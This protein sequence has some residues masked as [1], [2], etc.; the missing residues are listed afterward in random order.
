[1]DGVLFLRRR[2]VAAIVATILAAGCSLFANTDRLSGSI[3]PPT[4]DGGDSSIGSDGSI[5]SA[6]A[7]P[8][9]ELIVLAS[10]QL[11]PSAIGLLGENVYFT[12]TDGNTVGVVPKAKGSVQTFAVAGGTP[13]LDVFPNAK[14][15]VWLKATNSL[16]AL[17]EMGRDGGTPHAIGVTPTNNARYVRAAE[18]GVSYV[19]AYVDYWRWGIVRLQKS[20]D[21]WS[22]VLQADGGVHA[23]ASDGLFSYASVDNNIIAVDGAGVTTT[24]AS[25]QPP[26]P[27]ISTDADSVF[28]LTADGHVYRLDKKDAGGTPV[29]LA[30]D[31]AGLARIALF[32]EN[33]YFTVGGAMKDGRVRCVPKRGGPIAE[34]AHG[35][36]GPIGI[37]VD[38]SGAYVAVHDDGTIVR[39]PR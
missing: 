21:V 37:A 25:K 32:G 33:V 18:D 31:Q 29:E 1:M 9:G 35:L 39:I 28:W 5:D 20:G 27:D 8:F 13:A 19:V 36:G 38:D 2:V 15:I 4:L 10:G 16:E 6:D 26:T 12:N 11:G 17:W 3:D 23:I 30:R 7:K 14:G 22:N 34:L 24:F